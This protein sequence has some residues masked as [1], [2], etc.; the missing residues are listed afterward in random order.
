MKSFAQLRV[1]T[2]L[3]IGMAVILL[4]SF[5][6]TGA[7]LWLLGSVA[8]ETR[9][10]IREPLATER[11]VADWY[12][13]IDSAIRRTTAI[14]KSSDASLG[15][16]FAE[17]AAA[18]TAF[19]TEM[20][21]KV[22][23]LLL[24]EKEKQLFKT[25]GE[26][27]G[28]Y[29][30]ARDAVVKAKAEGRADEAA[31][32]LDGSFVPAAKR[33]QELV[34]QLL[35]EQRREIDETAAAIDAAYRSSRQVLIALCALSLLAGIAGAA[36]VTRSILRQLGGEPAYAAEI[37]NSIA[38][39]DLSV[40]VALAPNDK[41][42]LLH[43]MKCMR[44]QLADIVGR[45]RSGTEAIVTGSSQIAAGTFDLSARTEEEASSLEETASSMEELTSTVKQNA[46]HASQANVL[47]S[48]ASRVATRGGEV[49]REVVRTMD[50]I[51][52]SSKKI[53]D[54][55]G[56]IDGIAFQTNILALNAAVEAARA[57]EQGRGFAVV[58]TEVRSLAQRSAAAAKE[59]K[60]L[61]G[62]SVEK[63]EAGSALVAQ[64]GA[65]MEEIVDSVQ[66][67]TGIMADITTASQEQ[68]S[69]IEQVNLAITQMDQVT[70]QNA[71]LVE[72]TATA[73]ESLKEQAEA[74]ARMVR[75]FRIDSAAP[76]TQDQNPSTVLPPALQI[77]KAA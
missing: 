68:S 7:A 50:S 10:M 36:L 16:F 56:V 23:K 69:G 71:S 6:A 9:F 35:D 18:S 27:R 76:G 75:V 14:A 5:A 37:A 74:L 28:V 43:A 77:A 58:A 60:G 13:T 32:M 19:A 38:A 40:A 31:R 15:K 49:V 51:S 64:A 66:R 17:E 53:V 24:T 70:Q 30:A 29:I 20:Q 55:I 2:R 54:I 67:V 12:R 59:I 1:A 11:H 72:E 34:Q 8:E 65:T 62:D 26:Q 41:S 44:D 25:I 52:A 63:T 47:A 21:Q 39:G 46:E 45:V 57:G 22:E 42:S 73:S 4:L 61:I 48:S 3:S 33:Y